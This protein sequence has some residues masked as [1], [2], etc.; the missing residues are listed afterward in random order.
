MKTFK[1]RSGA[2]KRA[3]KS[4][5]GNASIVVNLSSSPPPTYTLLFEKVND[6]NKCY[7]PNSDPNSDYSGLCCYT[8]TIATFDYKPDPDT[9]IYINVYFNLNNESKIFLENSEN[10]AF[11]EYDKITKINILNEFTYSV[12]YNSKKIESTSTKISYIIINEEK[13]TV[14]KNL[15]T[16]IIKGQILKNNL[17]YYDKGFYQI[18]TSNGNGSVRMEVL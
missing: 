10:V 4:V 1:T 5:D 7:L 16:L 14:L 8:V 6:C 13:N 2:M 17:S 15:D 9:N 3:N 11:N 18:L 12:K